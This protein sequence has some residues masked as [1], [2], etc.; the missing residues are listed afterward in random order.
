MQHE[1]CCRQAEQGAYYLAQQPTL[2]QVVACCTPRPFHAS[3]ST[4]RSVADLLYK[5]NQTSCCSM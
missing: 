2:L 1:N 5:G 3:I 4:M